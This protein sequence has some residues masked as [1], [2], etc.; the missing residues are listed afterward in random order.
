MKCLRILLISLLLQPS[1]SFIAATPSTNVLVLSSYLDG[2]NGDSKNKR[3]PKSNYIKG[4]GS[5]GQSYLDTVGSRIEPQ[6]APTEAY[7]S[8]PTQPSTTP[9]QANVPDPLIPNP[10]NGENNIVR[11]ILAWN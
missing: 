4:S 2:L 11:K 8:L 1:K 6:S 9:Q 10:H 7:P 3:G 5:V